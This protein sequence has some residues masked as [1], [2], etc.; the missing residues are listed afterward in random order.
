MTECNLLN[1][2]TDEPMDAVV[3]SI[4]TENGVNT[5]DIRAI[6]SAYE[7]VLYCTH[8]E[9]E[10]E[11]VVFSGHI[12]LFREQNHVSATDVPY[13]PFITFLRMNEGA[14]P[15]K[16]P[17][18]MWVRAKTVDAVHLSVKWNVQ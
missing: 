14:E 10:R 6:T 13:T 5:V 2:G 17:R 18:V 15:I 4:P 11:N 7:P 3:E 9:N 1:I 8:T 16:H 12:H